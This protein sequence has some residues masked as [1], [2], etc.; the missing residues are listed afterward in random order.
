VNA[1]TTRDALRARTEHRR[2]PFWHE[3]PHVPFSDWQAA[4]PW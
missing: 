3:S 2:Q 1:V 4:G